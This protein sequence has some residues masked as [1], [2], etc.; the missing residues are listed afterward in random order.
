MGYNI[1]VR[2]WINEIDEKNDDYSQ[3]Q[4]SRDLTHWPKEMN[5]FWY[6]D[7]CYTEHKKEDFVNILKQKM[8]EFDINSE[9]FAKILKAFSEI[10][11]EPYF[12]DA[13]YISI[14]CN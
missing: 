13:K 11:N 9:E 8:N 4:L 5:K 14:T 10:V 6:F 3:I 7:M 2:F 1:Y 12:I